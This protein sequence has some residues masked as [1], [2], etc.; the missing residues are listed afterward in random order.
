MGPGGPADATIVGF[1]N[2]LI[3]GMRLFKRYWQPYEGLHMFTRVLVF[4][5]LKLF[6]MRVLPL[7]DFGSFLLG[8]EGKSN[9]LLELTSLMVGFIPIAAI[10]VQS[11]HLTKQTCIIGRSQKGNLWSFNIAVENHHSYS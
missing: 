11:P 7:G 2:Q 10:L 4:V 8:T 6:P 5:L 1:I 3:T 9:M